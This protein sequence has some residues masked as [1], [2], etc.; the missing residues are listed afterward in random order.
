MRILLFNIVVAAV[1]FTTTSGCSRTSEPAVAFK[2]GDI[3][4]M[5]NKSINGLKISM[6]N[7][8]SYNKISL[9]L[10]CLNVDFIH[11][12]PGH[13]TCDCVDSSDPC[14]ADGSC[15]VTQRCPESNGK[16]AGIN[17]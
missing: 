17:E 9:I 1:G 14:F 16:N 6:L 13:Y 10:A 11:E 5:V 7:L 15:V 2:T 12:N 4:L 8:V 3:F